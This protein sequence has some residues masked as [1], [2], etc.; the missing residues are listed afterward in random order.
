MVFRMDDRNENKN[1]VP[2]VFG[3][4]G[5]LYFLFF[6]VVLPGELLIWGT[7]VNSVLAGSYL[8]KRLKLSLYFDVP[9]GIFLAAGI[10]AL[11]CILRASL[12]LGRRSHAGDML[13]YGGFPLYMLS[14]FLYFQLPCAVAFGIPLIILAEA[15]FWFA[16]KPPQRPSFL[17]PDDWR[18]PASLTQRATAFFQLLPILLAG[19]LIFQEG[20][21]WWFSF[22]WTPIL[23]VLPLLGILLPRPGQLREYIGSSVYALLTC[24]MLYCAGQLFAEGVILTDFG[25]AAAYIFL[26]L[27]CALMIRPLLPAV[28]NISL[29]ILGLSSVSTCWIMPP[30]CSPW[31]VTLTMYGLYLFIDNRKTIWKKL[32]SRAH[33]RYSQVHVLSWEEYA[34]QACGFGAML[35]AWL[36]GPPYI[37]QILIGTAAVLAGSLIR[38]RLLSN[39]LQDH[40]VLMKFPYAIEITLLLLTVMATGFSR[41]TVMILLSA[42]AAAACLMRMIWSIGGLIG[43]YTRERPSLQLFYIFSYGGMTFLLVLLFLI[44]APATVLLGFF[45]ILSG[46]VNIGAASYRKKSENSELTMGWVQMVAGQFVFSAVPEVSLPEPEWSSGAAV[47]ALMAC[48]AL[49]VYCLFDFS[50]WK[51]R[52]PEYEK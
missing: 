33:F 7:A 46:I 3:L 52:K 11:I 39:P 23:A 17:L 21:L 12:E 16:G 50:N 24:G 8:A 6:A 29:V 51:R 9:R 30:V 27:M 10:L 1:G 42:F 14:L 40:L 41:G 2:P 34:A 49:Y 31:I 26:E 22:R 48:A 5:F 13:L 37:P 45:C 15:A 47:C 36:A 25:I 20:C 44:R 28:G 35:A 38:S 43:K 4:K 32:L 18:T 19:S